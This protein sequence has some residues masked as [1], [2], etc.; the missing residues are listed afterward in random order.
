MNKQG[1]G[2][3]K[4][5]FAAGCADRRHKRQRGDPVR[6]RDEQ[7]ARNDEDQRVDA[8]RPRG[9]IPFFGTSLS[10]FC[11]HSAYPFPFSVSPDGSF[12]SP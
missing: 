9:G 1:K 10:G 2:N 5:N 8:I 4:E 3:L 7:D 11:W 6:D 12:L